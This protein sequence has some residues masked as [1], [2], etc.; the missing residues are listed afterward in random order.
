[1]RVQGRVATFYDVKVA[2]G[3]IVG[4]NYR[5]ASSVP[6]AIELYCPTASAFEISVVVDEVHSRVATFCDINIAVCTVAVRNNRIP[7]ST[8]G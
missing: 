3:I 7:I 8:D 1:M 2:V 6:M 4:R 5:E